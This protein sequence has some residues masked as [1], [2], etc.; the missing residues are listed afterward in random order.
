MAETFNL[1]ESRQNLV[2]KDNE[3]IQKSRFSL[4]MTENKAIQYLISKIQPGDMPGKHYKFNCKEF[5]AL[6][7]WDEDVSYTKVKTMLTKLGMMQWWIDLDDDN[8][9]L[10]R[11]FHIIHMNKGTGEIEISFHEDMVPFLLALQESKELDGHYYTTYKLQ[12][13]TL[14]KHR[15]SPRIYELLKSYSNKRKWVFE[16]GTGTV[17]DIQRR[18][19]DTDPATGKSLVPESWSNWAIFK[20]DVLEPAKKEINLY[21]DIKIDYEGIKQD[22]HHKKTRAIRTIEFYMVGKTEPEQ[23]RTD[24]YIDAE[25]VEIE[26]DSRYHQFTLEEISVENRFFTAHE[27][28]LEEERKERAILEEEEKQKKIDES[29]Y[30]ILTSCLEGAYTEKQICFLYNEAI[31]GRVAGIVDISNWEMF[32]TDLVTHYQSIIEAT[33]EDTKS[34]PFRRL[35]D[36]VKKDYEG[37]VFTLQNQYR[38]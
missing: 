5:Q 37:I 35:M 8:E 29:K 12:N 9:A 23:R 21:T 33:P 30:P 24:E 18:I 31:K 38:K 6:I 13:I 3:M 7:K 4:S 32:A 27:D 25:Y 11:W 16:N 14:M 17:Y 34:T 36:M 28:S 22:I 10:V 26:D 1:K 15:Y 2:A 19:A 20:R